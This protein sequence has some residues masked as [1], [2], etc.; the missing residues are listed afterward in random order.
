M[1]NYFKVSEFCISDEPVPLDI[2]DKILKFHIVP[3]NK[4]REDLGFAIWPSQRSGYR[5]VWW[6][7]KKG[8]EGNS[9]HTFKGNGA[10]DLTCKDFA[11]NK[12]LLLD[13]LIRLTDYTRLAIYP[14][15]IHVDYGS[16]E[17]WVYDENWVKQYEVT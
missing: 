13:A 8:R 3:L 4:V 2:A 16:M 15:F 11:D 17:R 1:E 5:P 10:V 14:T 7:K 9:Q 6:E 12:W